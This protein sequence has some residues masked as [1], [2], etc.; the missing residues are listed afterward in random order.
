MYTRTFVLSISYP[1]DVS[2]LKQISFKCLQNP[3]VRLSGGASEEAW[4][5]GIISGSGY[6]TALTFTN[7]FTVRL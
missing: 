3:S 2:I 5:S 4:Q 6:G 1:S 7:S